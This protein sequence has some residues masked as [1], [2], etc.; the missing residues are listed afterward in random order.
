MAAGTPMVD[1]ER[2]DNI[3]SSAGVNENDVDF[4][5]DEMDL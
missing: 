4:L 2:D 1:N 5:L 3:I